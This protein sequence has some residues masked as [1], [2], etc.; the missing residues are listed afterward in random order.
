[1]LY[2]NG[3]ATVNGS[4]VSSPRTITELAARLGVS[5]MTVHRAIS[6]KPDIAAGTRDRILGEIE[7]LGWRPNMAARGLR[8]G[9]TY[10]LGIL[11]SDVA[12]SF[13]PEVLRGIDR[14]AEARGYHTF[15]CTHEHEPLRA[16]RHLRTLQSKGVD[17]MVHYP[18]HAC[19]E[20]PLLN[21]IALHTPAVVVM[22]DLP[23]FDGPAVLVD[24][25]QGG[26]LAARHLAQLGHRQIAMLGYEE[27]DFAAARRRGFLEGMAEA[28]LSV[29]ENWLVRVDPTDRGARGATRALFAGGSRPT[30]LFCSSDRIAARAMQELADLGIRVPQDVSV[31]GFNGDPWGGLLAAPLTTV[32]QPRHEVGERAARL[33]LEGAGPDQERRRLVLEPSLVLRASTAPYRPNGH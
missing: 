3:N 24:D 26:R 22:R 33:V 28:G 31:I 8:Q 11:I 14:A 10:T 12:A 2:V 9:R 27:G 18:T 17:A 32:A 29:P 7:R 25:V 20:A 13:L 16:E 1:V 19:D 5:T 4:H 15:V 23:G 21:D 6:G 30:A